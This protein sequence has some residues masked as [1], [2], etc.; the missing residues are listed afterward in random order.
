[1]VVNGG[2]LGEHKGINAPGVALPAAAVTKKDEDGPE[3]RPGARRRPRRAELRA[4]ARRLPRRHGGSCARRKRRAADR[5][6]RAPAGAGAPRRDPR[7][8]RRRDGGARRSRA[9]VPARAGAAHPEDDHRARPRART[10]GDPRDAGPRIDADRAAPDARRS[11]RRGDRGRSG[12]GRDHAG[13]G[14]RGRRLSG[15]SDP[16]A[17]R[18][19]PRRGDGGHAAALVGPNVSLFG[20]PGSDPSPDG[21]DAFRTVH[22]RAM[23]EAA[24]TLAS[25]GQAEAIVAVTQQGKTAQLLSSLRPRAAIVAIT[26]SD[27]GRAPAQALLGRPAGRVAISKTCARSSRRSARRSISR[28]MRWWCSSTSTRT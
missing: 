17:D 15:R 9:R 19:H 21:F 13:G 14:D 20:P 8:R 24:V 12:G 23:C 6:D 4:D 3:V 2:K 22:G 16:D 18:D 27:V 5:E 1:M 7:G 26:P 28:R 25:T 10:S 11:Q